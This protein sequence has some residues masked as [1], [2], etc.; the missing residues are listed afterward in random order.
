[1]SLEVSY[2]VITLPSSLSLLALC[3]RTCRQEARQCIHPPPACPSP[4]GRAPGASQLLTARAASL[5]LVGITC[6][7]AELVLAPFHTMYKDLPLLRSNSCQSRREKEKKK[8][9]NLPQNKMLASQPDLLLTAGSWNA[10]LHA[11]Q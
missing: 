11:R 9:H 8:K 6:F 4:S 10:S 5:C 2:S 7:L 1:M 3:P